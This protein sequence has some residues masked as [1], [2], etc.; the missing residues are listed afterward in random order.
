MATT[1]K[2][3]VTHEELEAHKSGTRDEL[4]R[5]SIRVEVLTSDLHQLTKTVGDMAEDIVEMKGD[6]AEMKGDIAELKGD[7]GELKGL[8][9]IIELNHAALMSAILK[10]P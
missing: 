6:M 5:L 9:S 8:K 1:A 4:Q 10:R 3:Y 7:V 2:R